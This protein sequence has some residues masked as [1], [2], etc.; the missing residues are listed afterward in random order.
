MPKAAI[1]TAPHVDALEPIALDDIVTPETFAQQYPDIATPFG[2]KWQ[3]RNRHHNGLSD[4][5]AV[6][7]INGKTKLVRSRYTRWLATRVA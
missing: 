4:A 1:R 7:V 5:G 3:I 6:V 2:I